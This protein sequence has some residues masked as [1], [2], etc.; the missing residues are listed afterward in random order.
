VI[1]VMCGI[2]LLRKLNN[3][4]INFKNTFNPNKSLNKACSFNKIAFFF[5]LVALVSLLLQAWSAKLE[6]SYESPDHPA[7]L[8]KVPLGTKLD[9]SGFFQ[10]VAL[11]TA[12]SCSFDR[13]T[14]N[15]DYS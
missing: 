5:K 9:W 13:I 12:A 3:A 11:L 14:G 1:E 6:D 4:V 10:G 7:A 15:R 8:K 2:G